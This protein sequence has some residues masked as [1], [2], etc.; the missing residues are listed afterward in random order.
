MK[1]Q[2]DYPAAVQSGNRSRIVFQSFFTTTFLQQDNLSLFS[3]LPCC[4]TFSGT[5]L[6]ALNF[7][8]KNFTRS[9]IR[10]GPQK[11][12]RTLIGDHLCINRSF[13]AKCKFSWSVRAKIAPRTHF[14]DFAFTSYVASTL[15]Y[16]RSSKFW[17]TNSIAFVWHEALTCIYF[18][19]LLVN[20]VRIR[21]FKLS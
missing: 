17:R 14:V 7:Y 15:Y 18:F 16:P 8:R 21:S 19:R 6:L 10:Y 3:S 4:C 2:E 13:A 12:H 5:S 9:K 20:G 1:A 11:E